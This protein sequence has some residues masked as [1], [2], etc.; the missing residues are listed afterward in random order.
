MKILFMNSGGKDS[1]IALAIIKKLNPDAEIQSLTIE[2]ADQQA[3][4]DAETLAKKHNLNHFV[5]PFEQTRQHIKGKLHP[6]VATMFWYFEIHFKGIQY[7]ASNGFDFVATG[8]DATPLFGDFDDLL[9]RVMDCMKLGRKV[10]VLR[11]L[12]NVKTMEDLNAIK[13]KYGIT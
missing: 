2:V 7:A 12:R 3:L 10:G 4:S 11:P 8:G 13:A 5:L 9:V 6:E 1:D